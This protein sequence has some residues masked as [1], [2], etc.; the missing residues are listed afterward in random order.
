MGVKWGDEDS[1]FAAR[2]EDQDTPQCPECKGAMEWSSYDGGEYASGWDCTNFQK[3]ASR[4]DNR[5]LKRWLCMKCE[6]DL[7]VICARS[8]LAARKIF[9]NEIKLCVAACPLSLSVNVASS[10]PGGSGKGRSG[11][12]V[13]VAADITVQGQFSR[14]GFGAR[15]VNRATASALDRSV[16]SAGK[17]QS[18][19]LIGIEA[20]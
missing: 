10:R 5:G 19:F 3:C 2:D 20:K 8:A 13:G 7:C 12:E 14:N 11:R 15:Q 6:E 16:A 17:I 18:Q 1:F 4:R 9:S